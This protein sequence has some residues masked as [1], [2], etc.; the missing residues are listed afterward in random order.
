MNECKNP[1]VYDVFPFP[2]GF[3]HFFFAKCSCPGFSLVEFRL[4]S[5]DVERNKTNIS[6]P[7][8]HNTSAS[9]ETN[10]FFFYISPLHESDF[11][12]L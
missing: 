7:Y 9:S 12:P 1:K 10:S 6:L 3:R 11:C 8:Q 2:N 4:R 5:S